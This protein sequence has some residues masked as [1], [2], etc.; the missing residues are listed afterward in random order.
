MET[1]N[2]TRRAPNV[3]NNQ[4]DRFR[5]DKGR[6]ASR[7]G[8]VMIGANTARSFLHLHVVAPGPIVDCFATVESMSTR[9]GLAVEK[10]IF[11]FPPV[12]AES[13]GTGTSLTARLSP[14]IW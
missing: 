1:L 8:R 4:L 13:M 14:P 2:P 5:S 6:I 9:S 11:G 7:R 10:N 12:G 3:P